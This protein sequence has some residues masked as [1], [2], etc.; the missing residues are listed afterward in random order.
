MR[1]SIIAAVA[2]NGIIGVDNDMPWRL[3]ADLRHFKSLTLGHHMVT[4]RKNFDSMGVL[5]GRTTI[6]LTRGQAELPEGVLRAG[7]FAEALEIAEEAGE[8]E[9]FFVGGGEIYLLALELADRMYMTRVHADVEGDTRFPD[10]S[11]ENWRQMERTDFEADGKNPYAFSWLVL[12][13][14]GPGR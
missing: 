3:S 6:V 9:L 14:C 1:L 7:S 12:D 5:P 2:A 10:F 8:D 4:G 11:S 13:R